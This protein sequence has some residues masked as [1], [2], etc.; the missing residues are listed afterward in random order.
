[1]FRP[2]PEWESSIQTLRGVMIRQHYWGNTSTLSF[3]YWQRPISLL[4]FRGAIVLTVRTIEL[5]TRE[6]NVSSH[7]HTFLTVYSGLSCEAWKVMDWWFSICLRFTPHR[8]I[9]NSLITYKQQRAVWSNRKP[10]TVKWEWTK[11]CW[12]IKL[13]LAV[14]WAEA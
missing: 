10:F 1:M 9:K 8:C 11:S 2:N 6:E 14:T 4:I 7:P 13:W 12:Q 5:D 3:L